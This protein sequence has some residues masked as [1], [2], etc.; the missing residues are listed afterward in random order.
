MRR[1]ILLTAV[2]IVV[3]VSAYA[4]TLT[5]TI[6]RTLDVRPGAKVVLSNVNGRI[7]ITSWE[8]PRV[9]IVAAKEADA[10]S[11][12]V[13]AVLREL[14]V[15]IQPRDGGVIITTHEPKRDQ[16]FHSIFDWLLGDHISTQ[17]RYQIKV[18][19]QMNL[20]VENTNG[21]IHVSDVSGTFE[22][23]TTNGKIEVVRCAG[24]LDAATTNGGIAAE[25]VRVTKGQALRFETT[26]GR[27]DLALPAD[28]GADVDAAT[29]NGAIRTDI[30]IATRAL[31]RN[32]LR[33][34]LNG[35][36]TAVRM[37]TTNGPIDIRA[38]GKS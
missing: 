32:S 9:Q 11:D 27:I 33:G 4:K 28:F 38:A 35:G 25:L 5:E 30:P 3:P 15:E 1:L 36:G 18:P 19:R 6:E 14:R 10:D 12:D 23:D 7:D 2:L 20:E 26:N 31:N 34:T 16:G 17:V 29:T 22:L 21:A 13:A 8:Q 37:R 24:T